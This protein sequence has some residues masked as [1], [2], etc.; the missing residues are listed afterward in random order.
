VHQREGHAGA[1]G[2]VDAL[3]LQLHVGAVVGAFEDAVL[4]LEVKEG[5]RRDRDDQLA[6]K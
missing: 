5:P 3:Q 4:F 2:L 1:C 6:L